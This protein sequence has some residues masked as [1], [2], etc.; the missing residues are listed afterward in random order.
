MKITEVKYGY[1]FN[2]G[3]YESQRVD[4]T[5]VP[6]E[7]ESAEYVLEQLKKIVHGHST[8]V[9]TKKEEQQEKPK[10]VETN[11]YEIPHQPVEVEEEKPKKKGRKTG[12][13]IIDGKEIPGEV[14]EQI[15]EEAKQER[16][17]EI[18]EKIHP[19]LK[20]RSIGAPYDRGNDLHKKMMGEFLNKEY[21]GW[22][23]RI[24]IF[25]EASAEMEGK[26]LVNTE[27]LMLESFKVEYRKIVSAKS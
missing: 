23:D 20:T 19:E 13:K 1:T 4:I 21:P 6:E 7:G 12:S 14:A 17:A 16:I 15:K 26:E 27:G 9:E 18:V 24:N 5:A 11:D 3:N 22:R 10:N 8:P 25:K 2:T